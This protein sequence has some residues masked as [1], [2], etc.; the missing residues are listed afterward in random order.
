MRCTARETEHG[1]AGP[2]APGVP[3]T[4]PE[5]GL[6]SARGVPPE[7][8]DHARHR[9]R[10]LAWPGV[11][12]ANVGQRDKDARREAAGAPWPLMATMALSRRRMLT[13]LGYLPFGLP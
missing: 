7:P 5:P 13:G 1:A 9:P 6:P 2:W 8:R 10:N 3:R 4:A 11:R 12:G